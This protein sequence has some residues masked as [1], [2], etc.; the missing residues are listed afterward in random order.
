MKNADYQDRTFDL[1]S[2]EVDD[3]FKICAKEA[4][5]GIVFWFV[6][7][8][9]LLAVMYTLG[10]GNPMDYSYIIGLPA[11]FFGAICVVLGFVVVAGFVAK[12]VLKDFTLGTEND[13]V[14]DMIEEGK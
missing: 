8:G 4:K 11:W 7:V 13:E 5:F 6:F 14:I 12:K 1:E 2:I 9:T 3:R 10:A